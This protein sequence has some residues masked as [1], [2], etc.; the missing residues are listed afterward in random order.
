MKPLWKDANY[1]LAV[2]FALLFAGIG[3]LLAMFMM[4]TIDAAVEGELS[5]VYMFL[6]LT[7]VLAFAEFF[8][9][10]VYRHFTLR[11]ARRRMELYKRT[12]F[13]NTINGFSKN[14]DDNIAMYSTDTDIVYDKYFQK[15]VLLVFAASQF[16]FSVIGMIYLNWILFLA[17]FIVSML[18]AFAPAIF[19]KRL[20][21]KIENYSA[22]SKTYIDY[23]QDS[24]QGLYEIKSF[25]AQKFFL[26]NHDK[27]NADTEKARA[28]NKF[29]NFLMHRTSSL[30]GS[31][32]FITII[33]VSGVLVVQGQITIGVLIAVVQLLNGMVSPIGD[34]FTYL[35]EISASRD[36][37]SGYLNK[38]TIGDEGLFTPEF[39]NSIALEN[40][41]FSYPQSNDN[42]LK[43]FSAKFIKGQSYAIVGES[44]CGKSTLAKIMSGILDTGGGKVLF[45][46]VNIQELDK[47]S[48]STRVKYIDQSAHLFNM[49]IRDNI[50]LG[51][52]TGRHEEFLRNLGLG[53]IDSEI[54][55][56]LL[57]G[58][59]KQRIVMARALN[60]LPD[61]LILDEPTANLDA[62]T[63]L[64][65][66]KYLQ[67]FNSLTLIVIT[68]SDN[69]EMLRLFDSVV[70]IDDNK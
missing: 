21:K 51:H 33:G 58:G 53:N 19:N 8:V 42:V 69:R 64:A 44:G 1:Y 45:D 54:D 50:E 63:A 59:Q 28:S 47:A 25:Y 49:D 31:F 22:A 57:S 27:L 5:R 6:F 38:K 55:T 2:I 36:L 41:S 70:R 39:K 61:V 20:S 56:E 34:F 23:V 30:L 13:A 26:K 15:H 46:S 29:V 7:V 16:V 68:H 10:I 9:S 37:A 48:Y 11:Y 14:V 3:V 52:S 18:P 66:F 4:F 65:T 62:D 24:T 60:K 67:S 35:G 43:N 40:V 32:S 17:A 12:L